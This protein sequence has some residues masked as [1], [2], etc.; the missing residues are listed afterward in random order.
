MLPLCALSYEQQLCFV[1]GSTGV[2]SECISR[3]T[4]DEVEGVER[5]VPS[6]SRTVCLKPTRFQTSLVRSLLSRGGSTLSEGKDLTYHPCISSYCHCQQDVHRNKVVRMYMFSGVHWNMHSTG[7]SGG[8][9]LTRKKRRVD[10]EIFL[11]ICDTLSGVP[12]KRQVP[13]WIQVLSNPCASSSTALV[14]AN[15]SL[16]HTFFTTSQP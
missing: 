4:C 5:C 7:M 6:K 8:S 1:V 9:R 3:I 2:P 10:W 11:F 16:D 15:H 14:F 13:V 12:S